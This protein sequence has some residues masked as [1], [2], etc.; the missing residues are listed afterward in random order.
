MERLFG[1]LANYPIGKVL[2][3][4]PLNGGNTSVVYKVISSEGHWVLRSLKDIQQGKVEYNLSEHIN[5]S[6][7]IV[8]EIICTKR[9]KS[10]FH[11][12]TGIY[13]LQTYIKGEKINKESINY[14]SIGESVGLLHKALEDFTCKHSFVDRFDL[15]SLW[16]KASSGWETLSCTK[17]TPSLQEMNFIIKELQLLSS[18]QP[19]FIHGDLGSWN[20][21]QK[22]GAI[23]IIDFGEARF[24]HHYFDLAGAIAST[25]KED[26]SEEVMSEN[27]SAI[28]NGYEQ[29][30]DKVNHNQLFLFIQLWY[31]RGILALL[32]S[33]MKGNTDYL[34]KCFQAIGKY[35][36][37]LTTCAA[38]K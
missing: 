32:A 27:V 4:E 19:H 24:G 22:D 29:R 30:R 7:A 16:S 23:Y 17:A 6:G 14:Y 34:V 9:G 8:P 2:H 11:N 21:I 1:V 20:M 15:N 10:F 36:N 5:K 3:V 35:K 25:I 12:E 31:I 38:E 18:V 26:S 13:H 33:N 28:V 37:L